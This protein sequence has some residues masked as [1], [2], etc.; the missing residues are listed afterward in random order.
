[1]MAPILGVF[2]FFSLIAAA[3]RRKEKGQALT[4]FLLSLLLLAEA[5]SEYFFPGRPV[6]GMGLFQPGSGQS[7]LLSGVLPRTL[8]AVFLHAANP[9]LWI[10]CFL[11]CR[12]NRASR[13]AMI[14]LLGALLCELLALRALFLAVVVPSVLWQ[15][16]RTLLLLTT[17]SY[18]CAL[19]SPRWNNE[20]EARS[21]WAPLF[22]SVL[23]GVLGFAVWVQ[24]FKPS[25]PRVMTLAHYYSWFP[26]NWKAG[27]L[28]GK[29]TPAI[30]PQLGEYTSGQE[31]V[32]HEH[33]EMAH[34][35][36]I[37]CFILDWWPTRGRVRDR[38]LAAAK[39]LSEKE[40]LC[41]VLLYETL[42]LRQPHE[43]LVGGERENIV[44]LSPERAKGMGD[45][46][47]RMFQDYMR[48]P[49]YL[50]WSG[51]PVLYLYA[52]RHLVGDVAKGIA[53]AREI[54][55]QKTGEELFLV[56]DEVYY[57]VPQ[58]DKNAV[59]LLATYQPNWDRLRA[60]DAITAYN[61]FDNSRKQQAGQAGLARFLSEGESLFREYRGIAATLGIPFLPMALPGYND[62][63]HRLEVDNFVVPR[64][65][66]EGRS[67]FD[68]TLRRWVL[69]HLDQGQ[70]IFSI[71]SWNEWNEG[72]QIEPSKGSG[73]SAAAP[74]LG[75]GESYEAY[76]SRYLRELCSFLRALEPSRHCGEYKEK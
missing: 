61:P 20:D 13:V 63:G 68:E 6:L 8:P 60:F 39:Q 49:G 64:L 54:V 65:L 55:R 38:A 25:E 7:R 69:P 28:G 45:Q 17:L 21:R 15:L 51:R 3:L 1:M 33:A 18:S 35:A 72:S 53:L 58:G 19:L 57:E 70:A 66:P 71:T 75:Q 5:G 50:H 26:E 67:V 40:Q 2:S 48:R 76:G 11:L 29:L 12:G 34:A 16:Q 43:R 32:V 56:G 24:S 46:W 59:R 27:Y 36:G 44:Y 10:L 41:T 52:T 62:R 23:V 9:M 31:E 47:A 14:F 22:L 74:E 30:L 42:D 37:D 73:Q 4:L